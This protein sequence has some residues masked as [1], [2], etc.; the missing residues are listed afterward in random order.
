LVFRDAPCNFK[1]VDALG[2]IDKKNVAGM[3]MEEV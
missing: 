1:S 3:L 2:V